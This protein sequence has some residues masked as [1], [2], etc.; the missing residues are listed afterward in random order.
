MI[1]SIGVQTKF[2]TANARDDFIQPSVQ[3]FTAKAPTSRNLIDQRF[4]RRVLTRVVIAARHC[5][6]VGKPEMKDSAGQHGMSKL[7]R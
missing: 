3:R 6:A 7:V 4:E 5:R 2:I 1:H